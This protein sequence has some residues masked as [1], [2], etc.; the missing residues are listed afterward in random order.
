MAFSISEKFLLHYP[1]TKGTVGREDTKRFISIMIKVEL[2]KPG[3]TRQT[4]K[5]LSILN[6]PILVRPDK[7]NS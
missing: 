2:N 6:R 5:S 3:S 4:E 1:E 7:S